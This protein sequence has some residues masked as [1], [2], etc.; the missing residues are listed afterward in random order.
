MR[1][2]EGGVGQKSLVGEAGQKI[3]QILPLLRSESETLDEGTL[4]G[5]RDALAPAA[6]GIEV[7]DVAERRKTAVVHV[8]RAALDVAQRRR[9]EAI[10]VGSL[11]SHCEQAVVGAARITLAVRIQASDV[12]RALYDGCT[13]VRDE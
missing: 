2:G 13:L 6:G 9:L 5:M 8:R 7:D 1:I 10:L 11:S 4:A 3:E 12:E